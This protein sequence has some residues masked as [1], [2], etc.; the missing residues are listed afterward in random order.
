MKTKLILISVSFIIMAIF[1]TISSCKK[2]NNDDK[3]IEVTGIEFTPNVFLD[4]GE[5]VGIDADIAATAMQNAGVSL[6]LSMADLW[7]DAY[8]ATLNGPNRALLTVGY[9]AERKDLFKWAG[10]T[11]QGMYGIFEHGNSGYVFPLPIVE[12]KNLPP[13]AVVKNWMETT[14]LE[15]LGFNNLVYYDTFTEALDA[16]MNGEIQFI[17]SDF[18]HLTSSLPPGYYVPNVHVV[19]R[20]RTVYYYI[21]FSKD[22]SDAVVNSVQNAIET[23]IKNQSTDS[24]VKQYLP[25]MPTDYIP[26]T[27]QLFT[28]V[29]PPYSYGTG[30]DT[31]RR[32]EGSSVEM[33]N[34]IQARTGYVNKIN[35]STW[36]DA[37]TPPQYLPNSAVFTTARTPEREAMFQWVGPI[38][39]NRTFFYTRSNAGFNIE[40]LEQAKALQSIA[41]PKGW[42]THDFL[43]NNNFNNIVAT[44]ITSQQ[45]FDQLINGEVDAL[46]LTDVDVKWLADINGVAMSELTQHMEALHKNGYIAFSLNTP[47]STVQEWQ[48]NLDAMKADGTFETIWNKWYDGI[49]MP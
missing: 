6:K 43:I 26:G 37:Y 28:E 21:A 11:S 14:T 2:D 29:A 8:N 48:N 22:V 46:L 18:Y 30:H 16:F 3:T 49:P 19:T 24:I 23:L 38:S 34:E 39:S 33:V 20:Y 35:L 44:A 32:V 9:S 7:Q 27:I 25:L 45:A 15:N 41:T 31:T 10:P 36:E 40:T 12:C 17:A 4:N 42:F 47:A 13:I 5:V 1:L